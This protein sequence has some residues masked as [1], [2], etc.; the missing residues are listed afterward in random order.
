M[1]GLPCPPATSRAFENAGAH[2]DQPYSDGVDEGEHCSVFELRTYTLQPGSRAAFVELFEERF[3]EPQEGEGMHL[4]GQFEDRTVP[5]R[6]VWIRGFASMASR[7][8]A[9]RAFYGGAV[10]QQYRQAANSMIVDSDDVHLLKRAVATPTIDSTAPRSAGLPQTALDNI[11]IVVSPA[12]SPLS[13]WQGSVFGGSS[14]LLGILRTEHAQNT[15]PQLPV[16]EGRDVLVAII[17]RAPTS[18]GLPASAD[19]LDRLAAYGQRSLQLR[20]TPRS[21]LR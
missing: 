19:N 2:A 8:A 4:I 16:I 11:D 18:D 14:Q 13:S 5:D 7:Q 12:Q 10:W 21:A 1:R 17:R 9:L 3:I 20:P 15:F 6:F